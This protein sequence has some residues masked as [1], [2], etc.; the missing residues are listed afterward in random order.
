[1][2]RA[3]EEQL[4]T[5]RVLHVEG[6]GVSHESK[7]ASAMRA[8]RARCMRL[9]PSMQRCFRALSLLLPL[10]DLLTLGE[11]RPAASDLLPLPELYLVRVKGVFASSGGGWCQA[12]VS[13][14][15]F[16]HGC[17]IQLRS[18]LCGLPC[19]PTQYPHNPEEKNDLSSQR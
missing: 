1:M 5:W 7:R 18:L 13:G 12:G 16:V 15:V 9:P 17:R 10:S 6:G 14:V 2:R 8:M 19:S 3:P 4:L 11:G